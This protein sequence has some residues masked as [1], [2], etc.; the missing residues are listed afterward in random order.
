MDGMELVYDAGLEPSDYLEPSLSSAPAPPTSRTPTI[1]PIDASHPFDLD[2][3]LSGLTG[4]A[5][6]DHLSHI[7][8]H[9]PTLA[10]EALQRALILLT[11]PDQRDPTLLTTLTSSYTTATER[12]L[13]VNITLP[14][15][16]D[17]QTYAQW[18]SKLTK[19]N[20]A[21]RA[22]L[23][24]ELKT[25]TQNMIKE[26]IR[27]AHR[28]LASHYAA[29]GQPELALRHYTK[30]REFAGSA[31]HTLEMCLAVLNLLIEGRSFAHVSTYVFKAESAL[32]APA[33]GA[34]GSGGGGGN[35][36]DKGADAKLSLATGLGLLH[37]RAYAKAAQKLLT[38]GLNSSTLAPWTGTIIHPGAPGVYATLCALATLDR[39]ELKRRYSNGDSVLG[40]GPGMKELIDAWLGSRFRAVITLLDSQSTAFAL[41]PLLAPHAPALAYQIRARALALYFRPF[42]TIKLEK[43]SA[44]FG[45]SV[46]ETEKEVVSLIKSGE[47]QG[48]VDSR[49]K[50]LVAR[51]RDAR[52][53]LYERALKAGDEMERGAQ[54]VLLRM[55]L[56]QADLVVRKSS[57]DRAERQQQQQGPPPAHE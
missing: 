38:P 52:A 54:G 18:S 50:V 22:K 13:S 39:P 32:D 28:D 37:A 46:Q 35:K 51:K 8:Q 4:R 14:P 27:L 48:R 55:K 23:E 15:F 3:R 25:Y 47:I 40:E 12:A 29:T 43:M 1:V 5:A 21:Q 7:I 10:Y 19:E 56:Q 6:L 26:S 41:D 30:S 44:A 57:N 16:P 42:S 20:D 31:Q 17:P 2:A 36:R 34:S 24:V 45:W 49:E 33:P 11:L 9:A 53:A